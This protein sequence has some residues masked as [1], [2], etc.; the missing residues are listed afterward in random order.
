MAA[1]GHLPRGGRPGHSP[2]DIGHRP[3]RRGGGHVVVLGGRGVQDPR[4][5]TD[6]FRPSPDVYTLGCSLNGVGRKPTTLVPLRGDVADR[7]RAI[8]EGWW[9]SAE[10]L[11]D[12]LAAEA[13]PEQNGVTIERILRGRDDLLVQV[14][15]AEQVRTVQPNLATIATLP[16][17]GVV[18]TALGD[19]LADDADFVSR[20]LYPVAGIAEDP[21][22]GSAHCLLCCHWSVELGRN[23]LIGLQLSARGG[24]V[25]ASVEGDWVRLAG[26]SVTVSRGT[27]LV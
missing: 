20:C 19:E 6:R 9:D 10:P 3:P 23:D 27:L 8:V 2:S 7:V 1:Y 18:I 16:A 25:G 22:T 26:R 17:R 24:S 15:S 21:V 11:G 12:P 4:C 14:A 13:E 5:S